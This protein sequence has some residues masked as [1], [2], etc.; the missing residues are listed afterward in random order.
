MVKYSNIELGNV[1]Y[2]GLGIYKVEN[3]ETFIETGTKDAG[4]MEF[5]FKQGI[6]TKKLD[7]A[8]L[9]LFTDEPYTVFIIDNA[10][11][12]TEY[13][14][15]E[16][17]NATAKSDH[18]NTTL[19]VMDLTKTFITDQ[20]I[21][22]FEISKADQID[23]LNRSVD[24]FK[25]NETYEKAEFE[26]QVFKDQAVIDSFR[27]YDTSFRKEHDV[28]LEDGFDISSHVVK[29]QAKI[30]KSE[31]KLDK[32]FHIYIHGDRNKIEKGVDT[33]GSKFYKFYYEEEK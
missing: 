26:E 2:E 8:C 18:I 13:W 24:Y 9:I 19:Q 31:L 33:D 20:I 12:E 27:K 5:N 15:N 30:F 14:T 21:E 29:K 11:K 22:D 4:G 16:F 28:P 32:N 1:Y 10:S 23:L 17:I 6:G 7:K 3:K 25:K